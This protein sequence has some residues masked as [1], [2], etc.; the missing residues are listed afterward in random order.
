MIIDR[1]FRGA[2]IDHPGIAPSHDRIHLFLQ[3]LSTLN[4]IPGSR[5]LDLPSF[6]KSETPMGVVPSWSDLYLDASASCNPNTKPEYY[7]A[8]ARLARS[9]ADQNYVA[10]EP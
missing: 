2:F 5:Q 9:M 6:L 4:G 8:L 10:R 7:R 3:N 1:P